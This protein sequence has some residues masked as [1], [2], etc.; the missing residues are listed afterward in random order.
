MTSSQ[1]PSSSSPGICSIRFLFCASLTPLS[2]PGAS[3]APVIRR[4]A[5]LGA[6]HSQRRLPP[7][8]PC[9]HGRRRQARHHQ[10]RLQ[11]HRLA[12]HRERLSFENQNKQSSAFLRRYRRLMSLLSLPGYRHWHADLRPDDTPLEAGLAFTCKLKS[13]IPFQG[14]D[15]LEKQKAEGLRRRIV[16]FTIDESV[17][18]KN[19]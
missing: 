9:R 3:D 7:G 11:G 16:C 6:A 8:L 13:S 2:R 18:K 1:V 12:Q 4:R 5:R 17:K 10:L 19:K 14:R 15:R